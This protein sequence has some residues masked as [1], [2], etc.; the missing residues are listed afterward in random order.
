MTVDRPGGAVL[1]D[2]VALLRKRPEMYL[3]PQELTPYLLASLLLQNAM[4]LGVDDLRVRTSPEGWTVLSAAR[5][6]TRL[7]PGGELPRA[8][9]FRC[10]LPFHRHEIYLIA[11]CRDVFARD[12]DGVEIL[13]GES[14]SEHVL[15]GLE[16]MQF[17]LGFRI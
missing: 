9:L 16:P 2:A 12:A 13:A 3:G 14:P 5:D 11:Y 4:A 8:E 15:A 1:R 6:W 17:H 7:G 10:L